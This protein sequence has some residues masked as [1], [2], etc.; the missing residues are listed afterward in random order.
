MLNIN[1]AVEPKPFMNSW[2]SP[3]SPASGRFRLPHF[4]LGLLAVFCACGAWA[5]VAGGTGTITGRVLNAATKG[6]VR[7]AEVRVEG[8]N[9][10]AYTED[11]GFFRLSGVP[12]GSVTLTVRYAGTQSGAATLNITG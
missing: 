11:A 10:V 2:T 1:S 6:Y 3:S 5:Q 8:T 4:L 12:A 9:L 7:N